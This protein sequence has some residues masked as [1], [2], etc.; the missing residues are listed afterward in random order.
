MG[1]IEK[2]E[3]NS[4]LTRL[5]IAQHRCATDPEKMMTPQSSRTGSLQHAIQAS[6]GQQDATDYRFESSETKSVEV[7]LFH[8]TRVAPY[9][10]ELLLM[11]PV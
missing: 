8:G 10:R 2:L 11:A 9:R 1:R 5:R 6:P 3:P 4:S 7:I